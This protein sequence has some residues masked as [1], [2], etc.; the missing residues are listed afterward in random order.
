MLRQ[1]A[2]YPSAPTIQP[3]LT[4]KGKCGI[5]VVRFKTIRWGVRPH[6]R[7]A[8][9]GKTAQRA[10]ILYMSVCEWRVYLDQS[11]VCASWNVEGQ[12]K[13][14]SVS[15]ILCLSHLNEVCLWWVN[16]LLIHWI[17]RGGALKLDVKMF[18]KEPLSEAVTHLSTKDKLPASVCWSD[19][20]FTWVHKLC[21]FKGF[22][23][24]SDRGESFL[25]DSINRRLN[26]SREL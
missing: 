23:R 24:C 21:C 20:F 6:V 4:L 22:Q 15:F 3:G 5:F 1:I 17:S 26:Y 25:H 2:N 14:V 18:F 11:R 9:E 12:V 19:V 8:F 10:R 7:E 13:V 16:R